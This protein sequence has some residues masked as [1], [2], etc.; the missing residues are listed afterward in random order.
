MSIDNIYEDVRNEYVLFGPHLNQRM[1]ENGISIE[2]VLDVILTGTIRKK[3]KDE[4]S[5]GKFSKFTIAKGAV[6]V[7]VKDSRPPFIITA[8]RR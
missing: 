3:E 1:Y 5:G 2:Q 8:N 6:Y 4:K 7:V